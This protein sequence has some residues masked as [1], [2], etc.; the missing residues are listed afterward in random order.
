MDSVVQSALISAAATVFS[1]GATAA[2][3]IT[4]FRLSRS[5]TDKTVAAARDTNQATIDAAH[6][7][8]RRTL[9]ATRDGQIADRYTKAVEQLGSSTIDVAIGGIYALERIAHDSP[10]DHPTVMEVLSACIREHSPEQWP[11]PDADG[12]TGE[13]STRPDI[14]AA[15]TVIGR[16]DPQHDVRPI[17]LGGADLTGA[18]LRGANFA[19]AILAATNFANANLDRANLRD[20]SLFTAVLTGAVLTGAV[21][22]GADLDGA[23]L[24]DADF[25]GADLTGADFTGPFTDRVAGDFTD[26]DFTGADLSDARWPPHVVVPEGWERDTDSGRLVAAPVLG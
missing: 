21:L 26:A 10:R 11:K 5:A 12:T 20:A 2:V 14:Q 17:D 19:G 4:G 7:D 23:D 16:R 8:V 13:R 3:A 24:D 1:V 18:Y 15:L 25:T 22:T 9:D 6:A